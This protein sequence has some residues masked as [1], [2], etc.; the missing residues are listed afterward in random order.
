MAVYGGFEHEGVWQDDYH[1]PQR[2]F[3]FYI[4]D[5]IQA[6]VAQLFKLELFTAVDNN[7]EVGL[8]SQ[9]LILRRT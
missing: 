4:D 8:H 1:D 7:N 6:V 9:I 2:F 5:Q 3:S